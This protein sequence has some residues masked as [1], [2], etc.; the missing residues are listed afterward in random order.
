MS[1]DKTRREEGFIGKGTIYVDFG[2]GLFELGNASKFEVK[3]TYET[4]KRPSHMRNNWG[5]ILNTVS[6]PKDGELTIEIDTLN[7]Q[8]LAL[9]LMGKLQINKLTAE[10]ITDE[11]ITIKDGWLKLNKKW[12]DTSQAITVT[13]ETGTQTINKDDI[14][15]NDRLGLIMISEEALIGAGIDKGEKIKVSYK[16]ANT[17]RALIQ[18]GTE[19]VLKGALMFDGKNLVTGESVI[20]NMPKFT[21]TAENAFDFFSDDFQKVT[22]KGSPEIADGEQ[23]PYTV[24][25]KSKS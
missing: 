12:I 21:M 6:I 16:T 25:I 15:I 14:K 8:N 19:V 7:H 10:T 9:A 4:K 17:E 23:A 22:F 5:A 13:D 18:A 1:I 11:I 3:V 20:V 24:E 2:E